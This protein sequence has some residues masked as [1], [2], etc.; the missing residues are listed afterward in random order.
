MK[1]ILFVVHRYAPYPGGSEYF[2]R[3]MAEE[4]LARGH[5]VTVLAETH[6]GD[7]N[8]VMV[9]K[10]YN[11][12]LQKWDL[13]IVH[14]ADV[15]SQNIVHANGY[16]INQNSPVCYMIIKPS[17]SAAALNG[18]KQ[19]KFLAYSTQYDIDY[20]KKH[21][22]LDKA[23]RIRHGIVYKNSLGAPT[24]NEDT[25]PHIYV[26]AGGFYPHKGMPPLAVAFENANIPDTQLHLY[27]YG[28]GIIY[29]DT[30]KVKWFKGKSKQEV[31]F[32][33]HNAKGYIM[34]SYEEGF[35][36]VLLEA[37]LNHT[38]W[39]ARENVGASSDMSRYGTLY[40]D[41]D[42]LMDILE[43]DPSFPSIVNSA[44]DYVMTNHLITQTCNDIEDIL[45]ES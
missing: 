20:L 35:G 22:V 8:G 33:I 1:Q 10:D 21:N 5:N 6:Q 28:E 41:E 31:M 45:N 14:G 17:E 11:I 27:G 34:N 4:M 25:L 2:V 19:H 38:P 7:L 43:C 13:I 32:A 9:T 29:E 24:R 39:Y 44:Y 30:E 18:L 40:K 23:R 42:E 3:D 12:L 37:M 36:L 16:V 26:S 15:I